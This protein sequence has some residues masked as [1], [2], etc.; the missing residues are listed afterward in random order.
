MV[1]PDTLEAAPGERNQWH[2]LVKAAAVILPA[3]LIIGGLWAF[4]HRDTTSSAWPSTDGLVA[5]ALSC[6]V[7][8]TIRDEH[9]ATLTITA[10]QSEVTK[11]ACVLGALH[12]PDDVTAGIGSPTAAPQTGGWDD[13][14]A[15]YTAAWAQAP[16]GS[17]LVTITAGP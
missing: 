13:V 15:R 8:Y 5:A 3:A 11:T 1:Q 2:P 14:L 10:D 17:L 12:A 4:T 9:H 7:P 16:T 6:H